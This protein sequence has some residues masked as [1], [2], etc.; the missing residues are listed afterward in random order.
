MHTQETGPFAALALRAGKQATEKEQAR[1]ID[2][3]VQQ[4]DE[5]SGE[6]GSAAFRDAVRL[7]GYD[8]DADTGMLLRRGVDRTN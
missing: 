3:L 8:I 7:R 6:M 1:R 4:I 2:A 5:L